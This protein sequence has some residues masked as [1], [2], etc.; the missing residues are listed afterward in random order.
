MTARGGGDRER[1][2]SGIVHRGRSHA[3]IGARMAHEFEAVSMSWR[4]ARVMREPGW[5][6]EVLAAHPRSCYLLD[7]DGAVY[8]VVQQPLGNGPF[9][10][11]IPAGPASVFQDLA[12]G[13]PVAG[14]GAGLNLGDAVHI[15]LAAGTL[16]DPK[17]YPGLAADDL[18][19]SG[20]LAA[21]YQA[22]V[23][24]ASP[25]SLARLLPYLQEED[26]PA[27]LHDVAHFPR[28]HALIAGLVDGLAQ[29]NR[30]RLKVVTASLAGLGPGLTPSGDD[31]LAGVLLALALAQERRPDAAL[32]EI[33][34]EVVETAAP[35]THE[36][37]AAYLR[38][39]RAGEVA[40]RWLPLL[41]ALGGSDTE[42]AATAAR[43]VTD[44]GETSGA[45]MLA[46]F[47]GG[48]SA[49]YRFPPLA[50]AALPNMG[51]RPSSPP[52]ADSA[53]A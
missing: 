14:D 35:R 25:A 17:A 37:S 3:I 39:A 21:A 1:G 6:G 47:L 32:R 44:V 33:A 22:A 4:V 24:A 10:I 42:A 46:G 16:W 28:S 40:E 36:I 34:D 11:V 31:F 13:T 51:A 29:R 53:R 41:A 45:D 38:A 7:E 12:A 26:L 5:S 19:L 9:S 27:P 48:L 52:A 50:E 20:C 30:R 49:V 43:A 23:D 8:A 2:R 18:V 15:G